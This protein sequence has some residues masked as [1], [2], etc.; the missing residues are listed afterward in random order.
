MTALDKYRRRVDDLRIKHRMAADTVERE[1]VELERINTSLGDIEE[2]RTIAQRIAQTIQQQAHRRISQVVTRCLDGV[3]IDPY[4]FAIR[5]DTKRGKTEAV[6]TFERDGKTFDDPMN[7][8]GGGVVDV[9]SFALR[10]SVV[11]LARPPR[12]RIL[13]LDEPFTNIRG[14]ENRRRMRKLLLRLATEMGFQFILNV[15]GDAYPEFLLGK[16]IRLGE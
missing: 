6:L 2:A 14:L 9:A 13:V 8:I 3:F 16:V 7:E 1:Q 5:F 4:T 15:D 10:L 11:M 12:R